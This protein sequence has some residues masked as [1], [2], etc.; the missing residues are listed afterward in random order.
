MP[1]EE[2]HAVSL[3]DLKLSVTAVT[4]PNHSAKPTS[5]VCEFGRTVGFEKNQGYSQVL[6]RCFLQI[7]EQ[8]GHIALSFTCRISKRPL[9]NELRRNGTLKR[10]F[11]WLAR[12]LLLL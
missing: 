10:T 5:Q 4:V 3:P 12:I 2:C 9:A 7:G 8:P 1:F 6:N 11:F